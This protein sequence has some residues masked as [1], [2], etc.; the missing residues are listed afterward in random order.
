MRGGYPGRCRDA[1][2]FVS[3]TGPAG[4][5]E[6][7]EAPEGPICFVTDAAA[8]VRMCP[9]RDPTGEYRV[10]RPMGHAI[11][12]DSPNE[13]I[14]F[15]FLYLGESDVGYTYVLIIKDDASSFVWLEPCTVADAKCT[16]ENEL[17]KALNKALHAHHHFTTPSSP[18]SNGTVETVRKEVLRASRAF[19]SEFRLKPSEWP[20]VVQSILNHSVRPSLNN[21]APITVFSGLLADNP[22]RKLLFEKLT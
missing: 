7:S 9:S 19:L 4:A 2:A 6:E 22:I 10:P 13:V 1:C 18:K 11:R 16:V 5:S 17:M 20:S 3:N 15:E 14:H 21:R 8:V 12:A